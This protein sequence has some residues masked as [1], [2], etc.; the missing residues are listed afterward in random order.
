MNAVSCAR[1]AWV[2]RLKPRP[3]DADTWKNRVEGDS[4][5]LDPHTP[6]GPFFPVETTHVTHEPRKLRGPPRH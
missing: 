3:Q 5:W 4:R 6:M 2:S 1:R